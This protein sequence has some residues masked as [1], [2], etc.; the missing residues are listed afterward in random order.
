MAVAVLSPQVRMSHYN[1]TE[2][3]FNSVRSRMR[4]SVPICSRCNI[5]NDFGPL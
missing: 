2:G 5:S 3:T 4:C 1:S